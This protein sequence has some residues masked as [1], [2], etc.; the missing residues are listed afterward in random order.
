MLPDKAPRNPFQPGQTLFFLGDHTAPED[1][2]Y[3]GVM[4]GV[5]A[6]FHPELRLNLVSAGAH[7][8]TAGGLRS[9]TLLDILTSSKPDWLV[10]GVGWAD[11]LRE[12]LAAQLLR[13]YR[14]KHAEGSNEREVEAMFGPEY[15][16]HA[17]ENPAPVEDNGPAPE[18]PLERLGMFREDLNAA[19]GELRDAGVKQ[20]LLTLA[21]VG[22]DRTH[23]VNDVLRAYSRTV[24]QLGQEFDCPVVDA[25]R[26]FRD[27]LDRAATYK[28]QVALTG[29]DGKL[30][31][32]GQT[33]LA[34]TFLGTFGLLPYPGQRPNR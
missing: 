5:L 27:F 33:L 14:E 11:A 34:R 15:H 18:L 3:V 26:A 23:P 22:N 4:S 20:I 28:Q 13:E 17:H 29:K 8:Q 2:G 21:W 9:R 6:R 19:L 24:R 1:P 12:P 7:G 31:A 32:Q 16:I 30:N 25:E 10:V